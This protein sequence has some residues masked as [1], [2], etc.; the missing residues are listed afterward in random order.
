MGFLKKRWKTQ[1]YYLA[2]WAGKLPVLRRIELQ[3]SWSWGGLEI[4]MGFIWYWASL[5]IQKIERK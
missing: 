4:R 1:K 2:L 5:I 3:I